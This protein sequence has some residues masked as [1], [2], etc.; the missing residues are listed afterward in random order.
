[1]TDKASRRTHSKRPKAG[2]WFW[3]CW[4]LANTIGAVAFLPVGLY[5]LIVANISFTFQSW[6]IAM[7]GMSLGGAVLG[8]V[9][10]LAQWLVIRKH[11]PRSR[12]WL[13]ATSLGMAVG[14][15][16]AVV[17]VISRGWHSWSLSVGLGQGIAGFI[18]VGYAV[19]GFTQWLVLRRQVAK[20]SLWLLANLI[21]ALTCACLLLTGFG[22]IFFGVFASF[23]IS[24][25]ITGAVLVWLLN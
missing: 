1:M 16:L 22:D 19:A 7:I 6:T 10:G 13:L 17:A 11:L 23:V 18:Y 9:I 25:A 3:L 20:S 5:M 2:W 21:I 15:F 4:V 8:A 14:M 12:W 24:G